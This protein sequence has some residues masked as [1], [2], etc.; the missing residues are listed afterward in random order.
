VLV[1]SSLDEAPKALQHILGGSGEAGG[2]NRSLPKQGES[3]WG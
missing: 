1:E 2:Q 3:G